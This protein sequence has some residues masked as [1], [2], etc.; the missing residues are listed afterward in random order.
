MDGLARLNLSLALLNWL[1]LQD[2]GRQADE[3]GAEV[4][5]CS[6]GEGTGREGQVVL[7]R[8]ETV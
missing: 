3:A 6:R 4:I 5:W 7:A 2:N 8:C 1:S